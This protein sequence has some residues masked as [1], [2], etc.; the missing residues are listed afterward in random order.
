MG[1]RQTNPGS[2]RPIEHN[3]LRAGLF[4]LDLTFF[5]LFWYSTAHLDARCPIF[6]PGLAQLAR[7]FD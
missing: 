3:Q 4:L 6:C 5:K 7:A 2:A 1:V